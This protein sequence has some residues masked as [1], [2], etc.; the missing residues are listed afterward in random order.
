M[1]NEQNLDGGSAKNLICKGLKGCNGQPLLAFVRRAKSFAISAAF[2]LHDCNCHRLAFKVPKCQ[3]STVRQKEIILQNW[4]FRFFRTFFDFRLFSLIFAKSHF[5]HA[6][7]PGFFKEIS[8]D[9]AQNFD[10]SSSR[11]TPFFCKI[12]VAK[13]EVCFPIV[14]LA[15]IH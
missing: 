7:P 5:L 1:S 11:Q 2:Y 14:L 15:F 9:I 13:P 3:C 4:P 10:V 8:V 12:S 6:F